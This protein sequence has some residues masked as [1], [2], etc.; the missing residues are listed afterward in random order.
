M[1]NW[2]NKQKVIV[3]MVCLLLSIAL[4]FYVTNVENPI[5]TYDISKVPVEIKNEGVA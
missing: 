3:Q 2:K 1:D 5:K 4:W